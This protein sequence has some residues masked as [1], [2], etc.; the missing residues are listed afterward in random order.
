MNIPDQIL[1]FDR[2]LKRRHHDRAAAGFA[3]HSVL[4]ESV[5]EHLIERLSDVKRSFASVL[6]LG[7][8]NGILARRFAEK[9]NSFVVAADVSEKML[10]PLAMPCVAADEE[11]LPFA[12]GSFDLVASNLSLH[13]VND[14]PGALA[15]IKNALRPDGLFLA[16][17]FGGRTLHELRGCLMEAELSVT[18]GVSPRLSPTIELQTASALL[19]RAGFSLPVA[20]QETI[21][22]T[23]PDAFALMRDLRGMGE[24]NAHLHRLR[25]PARHAVF[26]EAV[27]LYRMRYGAADG[28][29]PATFEVL[30]LHGWKA[31]A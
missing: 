18:G 10:R 4:F 13:W 2:A 30:F 5:A 11:L 21:R 24:A 23:Y 28:R 15:Q 17:V 31:A 22:L 20:D 14:L 19:Q 12:A 25:T 9:K 3:A 1:V 6:D 7:S 29:I 8:H 26:T 27:R 16:T